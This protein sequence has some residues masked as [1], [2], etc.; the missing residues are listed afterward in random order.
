MRPLLRRVSR[1]VL[2]VG[3]RD[4]VLSLLAAAWVAHVSCSLKRS[5]PSHPV[6]TCRQMVCL[7]SA[8][9]PKKVLLPSSLDTVLDMLELIA[10]SEQRPESEAGYF[11][12]AFAEQMPISPS[13]RRL[14]LVILQGCYFVIARAMGAPLLWSRTATMIFMFRQT[15]CNENFLHLS[16]YVGDRTFALHG[17]E[18]GRDSSVCKV[19]M[20]SLGTCE[21]CAPPR[22]EHPTLQLCFSVGMPFVAMLWKLAGFTRGKR[23][24][25]CIW[26]QQLLPFRPRS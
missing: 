22:A 21:C 1:G 14:F 12:F 26:T 2:P 15:L 24:P 5:D 9:M 4:F 6:L 3:C 10:A 7:Q 25:G 8:R 20:V 13:K 23:P 17:S 11:V 19:I 18:A 16:R